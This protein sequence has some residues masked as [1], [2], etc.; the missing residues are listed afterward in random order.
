MG[1]SYKLIERQ[2]NTLTEGGGGG[3]EC[4]MTRRPASFNIK[5]SV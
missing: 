1:I 5:I 4:S 2:K 3:G